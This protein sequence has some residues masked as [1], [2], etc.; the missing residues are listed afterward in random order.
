[1]LLRLFGA[2]PDQHQRHKLGPTL[3]PR[4]GAALGCCSVNQ[5]QVKRAVSEGVRE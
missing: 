1:M 2:T 5:V 3:V 4:V